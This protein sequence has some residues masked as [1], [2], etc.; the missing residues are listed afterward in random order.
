MKTFISKPK[1]KLTVGEIVDAMATTKEFVKYKR[2]DI[3]SVVE[4]FIKEYV[5]LPGSFV[6]KKFTPEAATELS[7]RVGIPREDIVKMVAV[8]RLRAGKSSN[9]KTKLF[10]AFNK[11]RAKGVGHRS[12]S[13]TSRM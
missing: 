13:V 10:K 6:T 12:S 5:G 3:F 11:V 7:L 4:I 8:F 9:V 2:D 1:E